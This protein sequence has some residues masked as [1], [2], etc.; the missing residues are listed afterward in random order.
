[1]G[2]SMGGLISHYGILEY[3]EVFGKAGIFS[4][5]YWFSGEAYTHLLASGHQE[6]MRICLLA[7]GQEDG[8]SVA[9]DVESM[10]QS[11]LDIGFDT[12]EI[13]SKIVPDGEHSE[14]FWAREFKDSY[15]WLFDV[16]LNTNIGVISPSNILQLYPNPSNDQLTIQIQKTFQTGI[17]H[18]FNIGGKKLQSENL[19]SPTQQFDLQSL[20]A[21]TYFLQLEL[22][23]QKHSPR[24]IDCCKI[25]KLS[26]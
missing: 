4:P 20:Q 1:M 9:A 10:Y 11:M 5:S 7:G 23:G 13:K 3:Q 16:E 18:I 19:Q 2:S 26:L 6:E 14:W 25:V 22:D 12:D 8:G 17:L 21:G 15:L 24:K